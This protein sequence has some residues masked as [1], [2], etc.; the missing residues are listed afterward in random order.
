MWQRTV[1]SLPEYSIIIGGKEIDPHSIITMKLTRKAEPLPI[2][3]IVS[4]E[5]YISLYTALSFEPNAKI[6]ISVKSPYP[7]DFS[8]H[9]ISRI[10]RRSG[11]L[12]IR[13]NDRMRMT[14]NMFDDSYFDNKT[15]PFHTFEVMELLASQCEFT[16][17]AR[18]VFTPSRLYRED[19]HGKTCHEILTLLSEH[20]VGIFYCSN[21]N[22]LCFT[23]FLSWSEEIGI[24]SAESTPVYIHSAKGP[25]E[26]V[27]ALNTDTDEIFSSGLPRHFS[28]ILKVRGRLFSQEL[29]DSI[30]TRIHDMKF[31]A[32][33]C[34]NIPITGAPDGITRFNFTE[35]DTPFISVT[36]IVHFGG[37]RIYGEAMAADIC[38]DESD[39][40]DVTGY[41]LRKRILEG[42][43]Y[44]SAIIGAKGLGFSSNFGVDTRAAETDYFTAQGD[45]VI[46]YDGAVIDKTMPDSIVKLSDT[47]RQITYG[48]TTYQLDYEVDGEG[49]KTNIKF[50]RLTADNDEESEE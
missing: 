39:Y 20:T 6:S 31:Q 3:G 12:T 15:E 40:I 41:E 44:G 24:N 18:N 27:Y 4:S 8:D 9:F 14:E 38:E 2:K 23:D 5:L 35:N 7:M 32:F 13:A 16:K 34:S 42:K 19:I 46:A 37:G 33:A 45:R 26:Q 1:F 48:G 28:N 17:A 11:V 21:E 25:F 10:S 50:E 49:N 29:A 43:K 30:L 47:C 22:E 36:T